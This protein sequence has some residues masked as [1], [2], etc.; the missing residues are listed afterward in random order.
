MPITFSVLMSG[1]AGHGAENYGEVDYDA[2]EGWGDGSPSAW[3]YGDWSSDGFG[4]DWGS[5]TGLGLPTDA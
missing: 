2:G 3:A 1:G 4:E 5:G